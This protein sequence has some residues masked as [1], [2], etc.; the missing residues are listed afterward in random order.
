MNTG[1]EDS[2]CVSGNKLL[3]NFLAKLGTMDSLPHII[4]DVP[5]MAMIQ[6]LQADALGHYVVRP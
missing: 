4:V 6:L 5:P 1:G 2:T 3:L